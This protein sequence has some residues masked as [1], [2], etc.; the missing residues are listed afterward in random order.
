MEMAGEGGFEPP[1]GGSKGR[2]LTAWRLP[3]L[4]LTRTKFEVA[5]L[6][7]K[8]DQGVFSYGFDPRA[9]DAHW[10]MVA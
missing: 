6:T 9:N 7:I 3:S 8:T 4:K 2:C 1:N 10:K 5:V